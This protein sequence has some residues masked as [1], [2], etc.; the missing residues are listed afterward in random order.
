VPGKGNGNSVDVERTREMLGKPD[1][2]L[3]GLQMWFHGRQYPDAQDYS[4]GNWMNVTVHCGERGA[5]VW[6]SGPLIEI[7]GMAAWLKETKALYST[8]EGK[9]ELFSYEPELQVRL[10][11]GGE[12]HMGMTVD[13]TPDCAMQKHQFKF[14]IDQTYLKP[15][16]AECEA[17][18][19]KFP[20]R[21]GPA[22]RVATG[23]SGSVSSKSRPWWKLW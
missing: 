2:S 7:F 20:V 18:L 5:S 16:I 11:A 9:A 1:V 10:K 15:F 14:A 19:E 3:A 23:G 21:G 22:Q 12:G 13:I 17:L 4:D 6:V 8:L